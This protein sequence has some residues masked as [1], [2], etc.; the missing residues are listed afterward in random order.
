M[1]LPWEILLNDNL[2]R[3]VLVLLG[4][5]KNGVSDTGKLLLAK[6]LSEGPLNLFL[7]SHVPIA[8]PKRHVVS[9]MHGIIVS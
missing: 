1:G 6:H 8:P 9:W 7:V 4:A 2:R 5:F 3:L